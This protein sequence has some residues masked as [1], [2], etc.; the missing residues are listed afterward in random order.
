MKRKILCCMLL[1]VMALTGCVDQTN[2]ED[3]SF[4]LVIGVDLDDDDRLVVSLSSPVF[5]KEAKLK[6]ERNIV[7]SVTIRDSREKFDDT[8]MALTSGSKTQVILIGRKLL[9]QKNWTKYL[10]PFFR[11]PKNTVTSRVV[12]VKGSVSDLVFYN[13]KDKPQLSLYL[14]KL[15]DTSSRRNE[16]VRTN[17]QDF[18][19]QTSEKGM[20]ASITAM[21]KTNK[22]WLTGSALLDEKG[23][24]KMTISSH[25]SKLLRILQDKTQGEFSFTIGMKP[26]SEDGKKEWLSFGAQNIKVKT[27]VRYDGHFI[28]DINAKMGVSLTERLFAFN[29]RKNSKKLEKSIE[30]KLKADFER[31]IKKIQDAEIDPIGLGLYARAYTYPQWKKVQNHWGKAL[32]KADVNVKVNVKIAGMGTI[33]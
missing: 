22:I 10:E 9:A 21:K 8:V 18:Y 27:K 15:I 19:R 3:V 26:Q 2:V 25:E 24:Y 14:M 33:K 11:D 32:S 31:L 20:T 29:V 6:Q 30:A 16:V 23:R 13:P 12:A 17:V 7:K 4:V 1:L 5:S 28:F